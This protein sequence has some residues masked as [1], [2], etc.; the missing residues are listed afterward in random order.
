MYVVYSYTLVW[1]KKILPQKNA[2]ENI[3]LLLCFWSE[4][5][6]ITNILV[7]FLLLFFRTAK[8]KISQ[9]WKNVMWVV[10]LLWKCLIFV[11]KVQ[12]YFFLN[13]PN[14]LHSC[15]GS[16]TNYVNGKGVGGCFI[17]VHISSHGGSG[18]LCKSSR[19]LFRPECEVL[20]TRR[21]LRSFWRVK[22]I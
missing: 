2:K 13:V 5:I 20:F 18:V 3:A 1:Q 4:N 11:W 15:R 22:N 14:K 16:F 8:Q 17:K 12:N 10:T 6:P 19:S 21:P 9:T 7:Q